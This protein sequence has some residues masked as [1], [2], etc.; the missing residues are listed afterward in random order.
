M[1]LF[2]AILSSIFAA[3]TAIFAKVGSEGVNSHLATALRSV[4]VLLLSWE[5][6]FLSMPV[7][8]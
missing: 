3:L 2:F 6:S 5:W 8:G 7:K 4:V 1:W